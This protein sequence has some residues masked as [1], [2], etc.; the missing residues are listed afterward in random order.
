MYQYTCLALLVSTLLMYNYGHVDMSCFDTLCEHGEESL[1]ESLAITLT[2]TPILIG[3]TGYY[4]NNRT[5]IYIPYAVI[6]DL[7]YL[8]RTTSSLYSKILICLSLDDNGYNNMPCIESDDIH[9]NYD[10][11]TIKIPTKLL[12]LHKCYWVVSITY[13]DDISTDN[14]NTY[15][16][17]NVINVIELSSAPFFLGTYYYCF[18]KM[19]TLLIF[20]IGRSTITKPKFG[21]IVESDVDM[22]LENDEVTKTYGKDIIFHVEGHRNV[23]AVTPIESTKRSNGMEPGTNF[24]SVTPSFPSGDSKNRSLGLPSFVYVE[25]VYSSE[26]IKAQRVFSKR[27]KQGHSKE[28]ISDLSE[29]DETNVCIFSNSI[30]DGQIRIWLQLVEAFAQNHTGIRFTWFLDYEVDRMEPLTKK[31]MKYKEDG[32]LSFLKYPITNVTEKELEERDSDQ[33]SFLPGLTGSTEQLTKYARERLI[34]AEYN[35]SQVNPSWVMRLYMSYAAAITSAQ[36]DIIVTGSARVLGWPMFLSDTGKI[37]SVPVIVELSNLY[38]HPTAS[39][40]VIVAPSLFAATHESIRNLGQSM[41]DPYSSTFPDN[42][43]GNNATLIVVVP[44]AVDTIRFSQSYVSSNGGPVR[45]PSCSQCINIGYVAR[46]SMEKSGGIFL[47]MASLLVRTYP[48][49]R[50]SI[51]GDGELRNELILLSQRLEISHMVFFSGWID[52]ELPNILNGTRTFSNVI[53]VLIYS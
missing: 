53:V 11:N 31:L 30:M 51:V 34:R 36:C 25:S 2:L 17:N 32:L 1:F 29:S 52:E 23:E 24:I 39:P 15:Y 44:P 13:N 26:K 9:Y 8:G 5:A 14:L 49:V 19:Y 33:S 21:T 27:W 48:N 3:Q 12:G 16:Y 38:L 20:I 45:Y 42:Y 6:Y 40:N 46:L 41:N 43:C 22:Q 28:E 35:I 7:Q 47:M 37:M 10:N 50:F 18:I 4:F